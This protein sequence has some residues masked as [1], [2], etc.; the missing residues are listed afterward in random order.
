MFQ[1]YLFA[2]DF[3]NCVL[4]QPGELM[5]VGSYWPATLQLP[6]TV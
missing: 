2:K 4:S 5:P 6:A 1:L 3:T